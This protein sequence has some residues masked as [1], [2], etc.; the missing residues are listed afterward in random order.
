[1]RIKWFEYSEPFQRL[2]PYVNAAA[3]KT[4]RNG[5]VGNR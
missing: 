4:I 2:I 5:S 1:M 3:A